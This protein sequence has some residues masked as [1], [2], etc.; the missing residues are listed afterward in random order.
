MEII[1]YIIIP[2][3]GSLFMEGC[4][5][6]GMYQMGGTEEDKRKIAWWVIIVYAIL[7]VLISLLGSGILN[8]CFLGLAPFLA[9]RIFNTKKS[10]LV[11]YF[12]LIAA[13]F[14][15]D[16]LVIISFQ[17]LMV[18][19][20][21]LFNSMMLNQILIVV[22]NRMIEFMVIQVIVFLVR[23]QSGLYITGRQMLISFFLPLFSLFNMYSLLY[24]CQIY[25]TDNMLL[26]FLA[27]LIFLICLNIYFVIL[28]NTMSRN[29]HLENEKNLYRQQAQMQFQYYEREEAKYNESRKL[30][31]DIRNHIQIMEELYKNNSPHDAIEYAGEVHQMLNK[32]NHNYYTSDKLLN[33]ILNDKAQLMHNFNIKEDIKVS[34]LSLDFMRDLDITALFTNLL[35]NCIEAAKESEKPVI[36]LRVSMVH[37]FLSISAENS[38][39]R[40]P[41]KSNAGLRSRKAGHE[42][43]GMKNIKEIVGKFG[44][45][46][47]YEWKDG[48]FYTN[49]MLAAEKPS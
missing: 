8:L 33:I 34:D 10:Y 3:I 16:G 42:G 5:F 15:T 6:Y 22:C 27:N 38:C 37:Q 12:I 28:V 9:K 43:L 46:M 44:G 23:R 40:E 39:D 32:F 14:I 47:N 35:D 18:L 36:K 26:L 1:A 13:V 25:F 4:I 7:S 30:I 19:G 29:N 48:I 31:H 17:T 21:S 20:S 2:I 49:I 45:D 11:Y 41:I 24:F